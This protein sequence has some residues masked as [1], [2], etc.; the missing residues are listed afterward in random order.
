MAR[1]G[2]TWG[3]LAVLLMAGCVE[4]AS[5]GPTP[6]AGV[7]D[8]ACVALPVVDSGVLLTACDPATGSRCDVSRHQACVW[9]VASDE[10]ACMCASV[11]VPVGAI[12]DLARQDCVA[13]AA[14]LFFAGDAAPRCRAVCE[15]DEGAGCE[16]EQA[17]APERA[18]ACAPVRRGPEL[19]PT[20]RYGVCVDVGLA[21]DPLQDTCPVD[22]ACGLFGRITACGARGAAAPGERCVNTDCDRGALCV[23]LAD[24]SG[25]QIPATCYQP[26]VVSN[27]ACT[28]GQCADVGLDFGLCL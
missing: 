15:Q 24:R 4:P 9:D 10:G 2:G 5:P 14:C 1:R 21:C 11:R 3:G 27:P 16:A 13:G 8:E 26:C 22:Q 7:I 20:V 28:S 12:C 25:N 19:T 18:F 6:D 17:A 23:T